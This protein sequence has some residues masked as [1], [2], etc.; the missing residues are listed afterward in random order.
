[1]PN[2]LHIMRTFQIRLVGMQTKLSP[3]PFEPWTLFGLLRFPVDL[4]LDSRGMPHIC[5]GQHSARDLKAS[6]SRSPGLVWVS[7][8]LPSTLPHKVQSPPSPQI[9]SSIKT[10][11]LFI[12]LSAL[13]METGLR[14]FHNAHLTS[15]LSLRH[16]SPVLLVVPYLKMVTLF[17]PF[18]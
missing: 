9:L 1:M 15:L 4:S 5:T 14:Q 7:F 18:C 11:G 13:D 12:L 3:I 8:L 16:H 17:H 10:A 6:L 2:V